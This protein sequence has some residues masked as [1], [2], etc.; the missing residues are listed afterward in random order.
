MA[1]FTIT[2]SLDDVPG[3]QSNDVIR[4]GA[5]TLQSFDRI[6]GS[7]GFDRLI[8]DVEQNGVQDPTISNVEHIFLD[9]GGQ[10][11]SIANISG[12]TRILTNGPSIILESIEQDDLTTEFGGREVE[13]GTVNLRFEDG[14]LE[15]GSDVLRLVAINSN[16]TFT[17]DSV[18]DSPG[19]AMNQTEDA[20]RVE[21][22]ALRLGPG[23][24]DNQVD[25]SAFTDIKVLKLRGDATS[26]VTLDAP[27]LQRIN[28]EDTT[29]GITLTNDI[30][31]DQIVLGGSGNDDF[32]TGSGDDTI[33]GG[34][35]DDVI[36]AGGGNNVVIGGR[37]DDE[38][39]SEQG[40]DKIVGGGGRD[41]ISS[42]SGDDMISGG[43]GNDE[44]TAG[45]GADTIRGGRNDDMIMGQGGA[46]TIYDG[47]GNDTADGGS[48]NDTFFA[49]MGDDTFTGA[50]GVDTFNFTQTD[51]GTDEVTDFTL[52][53]DAATNDIVVF[54]AFEVERT[55]QSQ[56]DFQTFADENPSIVTVDGNTDTV[57]IDADEGTIIL[58]VS[59]AD[60][61]LA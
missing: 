35:G 31:G 44:I 29:G 19:G 4:G 10:A 47:M 33:R 1:Q 42:G 21:G 32:K 16:V 2:T 55:L 18:Y 37:G 30:A 20:K 13:S 14:A 61:L 57:T 48:D 41:I 46:D 15:G 53:S 23:D 54:D 22:I 60:F 34:E 51:F 56:E 3:T 12:A 24:G 50:G 5:G 6:D 40:D 58:Q 43:F 25:I 39:T 38:I 11:F 9:T 45:D 7:G 17:S 36:T 49:G 59:D 26:K 27:E 28:A 52:T 8:A